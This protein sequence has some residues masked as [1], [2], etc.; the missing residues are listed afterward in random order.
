MG[1]LRM[2]AICAELEDAGRSGELE[3]AAT[4]AK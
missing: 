4:L 1:A 3:E 2:S